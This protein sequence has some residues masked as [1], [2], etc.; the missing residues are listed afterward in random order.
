M[1]SNGSISSFIPAKF[2]VKILVGAHTRQSITLCFSRPLLLLLGLYPRP[3]TP[4][5]SLSDIAAGRETQNDNKN[6][7]IALSQP[8]LFRDFR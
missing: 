3:P 8:S 4:L 6:N 7:I 5:H 1:T 2:C